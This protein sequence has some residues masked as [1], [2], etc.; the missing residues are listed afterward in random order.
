MEDTNATV[1]STG[2]N[3]QQPQG[4][5]PIWPK[6]SIETMPPFSPTFPPNL[7]L[8]SNGSFQV[9]KKPAILTNHGCHNIGSSSETKSFFRPPAASSSLAPKGD[10]DRNKKTQNASLSSDDAIA[11]NIVASAS[12][13][14]KAETL[15]GTVRIRWGKNLN[16]NME[17]KKMKRIISNRVSAQKSRMK[18]LQY[19]T[20]ME[21]KVKALEAQI[22]VLS[23]QVALYKNQQCLLQMEQ[24]SLNQQMLHFNTNKI[25]RDAEIEENKTEVN[26]LRQLHLSQKQQ[27]IQATQTSFLNWETVGI[28]Q[29]VYPNLNQRRMREM[30]YANSTQAQNN[31]EN[32]TQVNRLSQ[33]N[34]TQQ[35]DQQPQ[36][37]GQTWIPSN[38]EFPLGEIMISPSLNQTGMQQK[39]NINSTLGG[40]EAMLGYNTLNPDHVAHN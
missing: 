27:Q 22:A 3:G 21:R 19:V 6:R 8:G 26:R 37:I 36:Q 1:I 33:M 34:L 23:P 12:D 25:L 30:V 28:E 17:P 40:I 16:P 15:N 20:D 38:W 18:K 5:T 39:V 14:S 9:W 10:D 7:S 4:V 24:R 35:E 32:T 11:V 31:G 13:P 2:D 29:M